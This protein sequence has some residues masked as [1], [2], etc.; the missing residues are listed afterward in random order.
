MIHKKKEAGNYMLPAK[1]MKKKKVLQ[2]L[3]TLYR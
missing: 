3:F 2:L 1:S